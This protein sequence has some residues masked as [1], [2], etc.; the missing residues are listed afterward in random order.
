MDELIMEP[1]YIYSTTKDSEVKAI[2]FPVVIEDNDYTISGISF[3]EL[4]MAAMKGLIRIQSKIDGESTYSLLTPTNIQFTDDSIALAEHF[5]IVYS[6]A[7]NTITA[8]Y[9]DPTE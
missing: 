8:T 7:N 3:N 9:T 5:Y 2:V 1:T 4:K 6:S